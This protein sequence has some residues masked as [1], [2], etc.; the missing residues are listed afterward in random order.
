MLSS[1]CFSSYFTGVKHTCV[2][3]SIPSAA[4][5]G[6]CT[7]YDHFKY[8]LTSARGYLSDAI[9]NR[10]VAAMLHDYSLKSVIHIFGGNDV[11]NC[12]LAGFVNAPACLSFAAAAC[13]PS[14][15]NGCCDT[16]PDSETE[17]LVDTKCQALL[18]GRVNIGFNFT[19]LVFI[20]IYIYS[21][22]IM[23]LLHEF[24]LNLRLFWHSKKTKQTRNG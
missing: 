22:E 14:L 8:G 9:S 19:L 6:A 20:S 24:R 3:F 7:N 10:T 18:Q 13:A 11:C 15:V 1:S 5:S 21:L 4:E 17:N 23:S 16:Y 2:D 12:N